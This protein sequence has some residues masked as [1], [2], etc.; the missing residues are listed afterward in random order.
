MTRGP[1]FRMLA[2]LHGSLQSVV[3]DMLVAFITSE[4]FLRVHPDKEPLQMR[5]VRS[6]QSSHNL[7]PVQHVYYLLRGS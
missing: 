6:L 4:I 1:L 5:E 7:V 2:V 3:Q